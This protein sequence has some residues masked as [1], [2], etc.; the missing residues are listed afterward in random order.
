MFYRL[1]LLMNALKSENRSFS[2]NFGCFWVGLCFGVLLG[3]P[4]RSVGESGRDDIEELE[5]WFSFRI[6]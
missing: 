4:R 1:T 6:L 2:T 5:R 3:G